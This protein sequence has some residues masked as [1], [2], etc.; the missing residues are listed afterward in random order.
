MIRLNVLLHLD[1]TTII[2]VGRLAMDDHRIYFEMVFNI[3]V[4]NRD[5]HVKNFSFLIDHEG[6]WSLS[7]A[8]DLV[9]SSGPGGEHSMT[10]AGEG[11][12]PT[13]VDIYRLS[14]KHGINKKTAE[15]IVAQVSDATNRFQTHAQTA[16]VSRPTRDKIN[17][18]IANNLKHFFHSRQ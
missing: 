11:K 13:K 14:E 12:A 15:Q 2:P 7:P 6:K 9:Y 16:G 10:V 4:N 1:A 3:L 17:T 5:D 8:Y 18:A